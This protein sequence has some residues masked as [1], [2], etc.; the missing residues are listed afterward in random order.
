[1]ELLN[2]GYKCNQQDIKRS[3]IESFLSIKSSWWKYVHDGYRKNTLPLQS[4]SCKL[5]L[6]KWEL[7]RYSIPYWSFGCLQTTQTFVGAFFFI[8]VVIEYAILQLRIVLSEGTSMAWRQTLPLHVD[9]SEAYI[10]RWLKQT[11]IAGTQ[12]MEL[13]QRFFSCTFI[14]W[15]GCVFKNHKGDHILFTG[16]LM[17]FC[18]LISLCNE[19]EMIIK[20]EEML[21]VPGKKA[22][23][24]QHRWPL[25][26]LR[27]IYWML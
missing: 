19:I 1:M 14:L 3:E 27:C 16:L 18:L 9:L 2:T 21:Y 26:T 15:T 13:H 23:I 11:W 25:G 7:K 12:V 8:F 17:F 24:I 10:T 22:K 4:C 6:W 5:W 20:T